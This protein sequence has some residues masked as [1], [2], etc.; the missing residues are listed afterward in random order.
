MKKRIL[1]LTLIIIM[2]V[3]LAGI[4]YAESAG[5]FSSGSYH[6]EI[7]PPVLGSAKSSSPIKADGGMNPWVNPTIYATPTIYWIQVSTSPLGTDVSTNL[8]ILNTPGSVSFNYKLGYGGSGQWYRLVGGG[9]YN[10]Y[11]T[12]EVY[13]T[14]SP[15]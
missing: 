4:A 10:P 11:L 8:L 15:D 5:V 9:A 7:D 6:F 13:G 3:L 2:L 1:V 14:W 12:Y